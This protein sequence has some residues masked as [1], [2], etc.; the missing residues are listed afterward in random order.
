ME[1]SVDWHGTQLTELVPNGWLQLALI[2]QLIEPASEWSQW[3][4]AS[5]RNA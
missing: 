1:T 2:A 3:P 5:E 4:A